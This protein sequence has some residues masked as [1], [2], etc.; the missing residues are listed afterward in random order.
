METS[1]DLT[2]VFII[3]FGFLFAKIICL[4]IDDIDDKDDKDY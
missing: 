4:I 1:N 2:I 3:A